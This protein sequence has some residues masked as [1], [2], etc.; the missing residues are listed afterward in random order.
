MNTF[1][2][3]SMSLCLIA[4]ALLSAAASADD[5]ATA[6]SSGQTEVKMMDR[7]KDGKL[8]AAEHEAGT[9]AMFVAMDA[10]KD[11]TVTAEE[12]AAHNQA[13]APERRNAG[14]MSAA[15]KIKAIDANGDG[16]LS[17][18]EHVAGSRAMFA[19]L[20]RNADGNLTVAEI[21]AGHAAMLKSK[22]NY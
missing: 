4:A 14:D 2:G 6:E 7:D 20:D 16:A 15:D 8:P 19:R 10:N 11:R 1:P 12:M 18:E 9:K 22:N 5:Q 21:D 13:K 3:R 17:A